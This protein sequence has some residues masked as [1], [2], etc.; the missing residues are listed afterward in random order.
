MESADQI[1]ILCSFI[2]WGGIRL[3]ETELKQFTARANVSL[4]VITTSYM[5]A[6]DVKAIEFLRQLPNTTI[7]VSYD[8]QRTRLHAKAYIMRRRSNYGS[9]Y[10]G[11]ANMSQA[12][13][14]DGLEWIVKVSQ[15]E[16]PY[17]WDKASATFETYWNDSEF[18]LYTAN[19]LERLQ[20]ALRCERSTA[21]S[22]VD[23][24]RFDLRAYPFQQEILDK[25]QA[26]R[27]L[28]G[29]NRHL[30][31]AATGTGKTM[32]AAFDYRN[33]AHTVAM[34]RRPRLLFIA[35]REEILRQSAATFRA[36]L[37]DHN[38][39]DLLA[40]GDNPMQHDHLFC[41]IQSYN[42]RELWNLPSEH[43]EY[44]V[45]D[46]FHRAAAESYKRLLNHI[47]PKILL[48]LTATPERAD[49]LDIKVYFDG[50][51]SA[52]IRLADAINR[53]LLAPFQYF[54]VTDTD[55]A[56]L[57]N[58]SWSRGGYSKDDLDRVYTGNDVRARLVADKTTEIVLEVSK[59]RGLGFCVSIEH[60]KYMAKKFCEYGIPAEALSAESTTEQRDSVQ[61][62]L[63]E[64][65]I[66][67][68]FVVDLYNEGVDIP[69]VDTILLLRPTN[70]LT[71]Y[72]QQLGRGLRLCD[73]KDCLTV[74]DFIGQAHK[75]YRFDIRFRALLDD[76]TRNVGDEV[77]NG[78]A[79][80]PAGS[81]IQL[82]RLAK[83]YVLDNIGRAIKQ[84]VN[85]L[86]DEVRE[87]AQSLGRPPTMAEFLEQNRLELDD[88]YRRDISWARLCEMAGQRKGWQAPDEVRITKG[89]RRLQHIGSNTQ[90][91]LLI[92]ALGG[93][94]QDTTKLD[95]SSK[96]LLLMAHFSLWGQDSGIVSLD[97][98]FAR[99]RANGVLC[100]ELREMLLY[101]L[102]QVDCESKPSQLPFVCP[103]ELH[104]AYTRDEIMAGLGYWTI[105]NQPEMREGVLH[106]PKLITDIFLFTLHKS[107]RDYSPTT[108]YQDY[109]I[110]DRLIHWQ[111]QSRTSDTSP[112]GQRYIKHRQNDHTILLFAREYKKSNT[113]LA[114]P[115][116]FLGAADYISHEGS[117]PISIQWQ[118][119]DPLPAKLHRRF[120]RLAVG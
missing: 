25:I 84:N 73:G 34:G 116:Y 8:T 86:I 80:L 36:V 50:H 27:D 17:L 46:E 15:Y 68:I 16:Q 28:Q 71:V 113:G 52:E 65:G 47:R 40:G 42:S 62:R 114:C 61:S 63:I 11:S 14:T 13:L 59:C 108:M 18:E 120:A 95:E 26:E 91:L 83:Q 6:T 66:N 7:R 39:G 76:P 107:E 32:I 45:V 24:Y 49:E 2:K 85:T 3:L 106:M 77:E 44:I 33:Y 29:R 99:L 112:T 115:Y 64:R 101:R 75:N 78:F 89:L 12:A 81:S 58:L 117:R 60:A 102:E 9:A 69:Q 22:A 93:G 94:A 105:D 87:L 67:F 92:N 10:I 90:I 43:F 97:E 104:A 109:A 88:I 4:R 100:E 20:M 74:L 23:K 110:N 54:G 96:R 31:V 21:V 119:R 51:V 111:S 37:R 98:S 55:N 53:K 70:S 56:D 35:H 79:H 30:V 38:F 1:D 48:G 41:S 57:R 82:E 103:L 5:G 19:D 118:L 72:L